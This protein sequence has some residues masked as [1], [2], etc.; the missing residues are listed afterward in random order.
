MVAIVSS[1]SS[2]TV[3]RVKTLAA[4]AA[5]PIICTIFYQLFHSDNSVVA[6]ARSF[7]D[8]NSD[9]NNYVCH[10]S[11]TLIFK[12]FVAVPER[13]SAVEFSNMDCSVGGDDRNARHTPIGIGTGYWI[14][15]RTPCY[16]LSIWT[17]YPTLLTLDQ[18]RSMREGF[19]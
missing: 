17:Q 12:S 6:A 10:A 16:V 11:S 14:R 13:G 9:W 18:S 15:Y 8:L 1:C 3:V 4:S 2:Q 19:P 5:C 7:C